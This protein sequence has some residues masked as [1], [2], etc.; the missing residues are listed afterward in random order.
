MFIDRL[1][2]KINNSKYHRYLYLTPHVYTVGNCSTEVLYGIIAAKSRN[3]KLF[4]LYPYDIPFIFKWR[5]TNKELFLLKS[6]YIAKQG[7]YTRLVVRL[8]VTIFYL[9]V[10]TYAI[11]ARNYFGIIIDESISIPRIGEMEIYGYATDNIYDYEK[12]KEFV[13]NNWRPKGVSI[14]LSIKSELNAIKEL[15]ESFGMTKNDWYVCLHVRESGF[16]GD[17]GRRD[18]RNSNINNYIK[19][20]QEVVSR[21]GWVIRMGDNKMTKLPIMDRVI[22]YPFTSCRSDMNDLLL[23]KYC[24]FY[25]GAQ[26]GILDVA[27]LF[28]K[29]VLIINMID[30]S[31]SGLYGSFSRGLPKH[32]YSKK[33]KKYIPFKWMF[34]N[35]VGFITDEYA[36]WKNNIEYSKWKDKHPSLASV[37]MD[38]YILIENSED[39]IK[40]SIVEYMDMIANNDHSIS[41][42]QSMFVNYRKKCRDSMSINKRIYMFDSCKRNTINSNY[43]TMRVEMSNGLISD[44]FLS[45]NWNINSRNNNMIK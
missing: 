31:A 5:L 45:N 19:G 2:S 34:E 39:E 44:R 16:R 7:K 15:K 33:E 25:I 42:V 14:R 23:I 18:Y 11:I 22:D 28:S 38:D 3:K 8:L 37:N 21:G 10:R 13:V 17:E 20:V 29:N 43:F 35:S 40:E 24:S 12:I 6:K 9:P 30:W 1:F 32:W 26:S 36:M 4:I 41:E 27:N